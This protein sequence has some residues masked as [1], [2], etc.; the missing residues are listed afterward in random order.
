M[1]LKN[2]TNAAIYVDY[3]NIYELLKYYGKNPF[4]IDFFPEI[5]KKL[6]NDYR[7]KIIEFI[8]Y[9]NFEKKEFQGRHQ[10]MIQKLGIETRHSS[11]SGKNCSDL[12]LTVDAL[13]TLYKNPN[14]DVFV[15][16]SS[17][18]DIIP[19][20][21]AIKYENKIAFTI[22][23]RKGFNVIVTKYTDYHEYIE[24]IFHLKE[25]PQHEDLPEH[26]I[27][28]EP[29]N[30]RELMDIVDVQNKAV[31]AEGIERAKEVSKLFYGSN[32]WKKY[33]Q[34]GEIISLKGYI[35]ILAK[36]VIRNQS[37]IL[38]DF[39][40]AHHLEYIHIFTDPR[41]G[42]CLKEGAKRNELETNHW[43]GEHPDGL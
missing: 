8:V 26:G 32:V 25:E 31:T 21:K 30:P 28:C 40:L 11:N 14:V 17:D 38:E 5:I 16:I 43:N 42:L 36:T 22:S 9:S 41:K 24:D 19:L 3:E 18:R 29:G 2:F 10:T 34:I 6:K 12:E 7:F 33:E 35:N 37:Q 13:R 23:T 27:L 4:D 20:I 39:K 15:L 1:E